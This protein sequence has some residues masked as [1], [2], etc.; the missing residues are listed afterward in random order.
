MTTEPKPYVPF[1]AQ[2]GFRAYK[3]PTLD[4]HVRPHLAPHLWDWCEPILTNSGNLL[5]RMS[6]RMRFVLGDFPLNELELMVDQRPDLLLDIAHWLVTEV[7]LAPKTIANLDQILSDGGSAWMVDGDAK[8]LRRRLSPEE[9]ESLRTAIEPDDTTSTYLREAYTAAW[10]RDDPSAVEAFD[11]VVKAL[12]SVLA[13][14]VIPKHPTPTLGKVIK[15]LQDKPEKWDTRFRGEETIEALAAMLDEV[16]KTQV[17]HGKTEYLENTI[18]EAQD[19]VTI[20]VAVVGLCRRG[21]LERL[22][23]YT[24]EEEAE[25]LAVADAA[26]ERYQ[27]ASMKSVLYEDVIADWSAEESIR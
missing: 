15:A 20:T 3:I 4:E 24:A 17:R 26:L 8:T 13:P 1:T 27:S 9:E 18:E 12:E 22:N 21:F 16:W 11:G 7:D 2:Q 19:A 6:L 23:E 10:R 25:D 14:V 5:A